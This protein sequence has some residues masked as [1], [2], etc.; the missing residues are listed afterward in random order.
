MLRS[1]G[2]QIHSC[3]SL[4]PESAAEMEMKKVEGKEGR[5]K[6]NGK[7][8]TFLTS[9]A[10]AVGGHHLSKSKH[11]QLSIRYGFTLKTCDQSSQKHDDFSDALM[12]L[13][14][15]AV[16]TSCQLSLPNWW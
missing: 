4:L 5:R 1:N 10:T 7:L 16:L 2:R 14:L 11:L 8:A 13:F 9:V 12:L 6:Q 15:P 3:H